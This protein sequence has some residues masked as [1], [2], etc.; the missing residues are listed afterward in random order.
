MEKD[1][2]F[3]RFRVRSGTWY[4]ALTDDGNIKEMIFSDELRQMLGYRGKEEFPDTL[5]TFKQ[6]IHPDDMS[7]MMD[8]VNST[9]LGQA[10]KF[11]VEYRIL[12]KNG[13]YVVVNDVGSLVRAANGRPFMM[14]GA[15]IDVTPI[16]DHDFGRK[17]PLKEIIQ[18]AY[19]EDAA[20][21]FG[22]VY[23]LNE[24]ARFRVDYDENG[25]LMA[26][27][28]N[29]AYWKMFGYTRA[30]EF[31]QSWP[32][33]FNSIVPDDQE[34]VLS[35]MEVLGKLTDPRDIHEE[36]FRVYNKDKSIH[37]IHVAARRVID[38]EGHPQQVVGIVTDISERKRDELHTRI[39]DI[40]SQ[41]YVTVNIVDVINHRLRMIRY[42]NR[43]DTADALEKVAEGYNYEQ[44]LMHYIDTYVAPEDR[45]RMHK[46]TTIEN[47]VQQVSEKEMYRIQFAQID[48]E[49]NR[50]HYQGSY[51]RIMDETGQPAIVVGFRDITD[52]VVAEQKKQ[53]ELQVAKE[54]AEAANNAKTAF[55]FNMSHDIRTPMNAIMG[56]RDLLEKY[57]EDPSRRQYYLVKMGEVSRVLLSIID[58]VLEMARIEKGT[59]ELHEN[60][61]NAY[62]F[63]DY[64]YS[65]FMP[66]MDKKNL[67]FI[68]KV[69]VKHQYIYCDAG[70]LRDVFLNVISNAY[71]YTPE[72][73]SISF[74]VEEVPHER[75]GWV[76]F[77][78][79]ISDTGIGMSQEF[80]PQ[81]FDAFARESNNVGN[82]IEGTGLGM[83]IVKR[84]VDFLE[85]TIEVQSKK[86]EGTSFVITIPHRIATKEEQ[87]ETL[88][89]VE[90]KTDVIQGKRV[91]LAEDNDIN[92][93]IA[94]EILTELGLM[95]EHAADGQICVDMLV[96]APA[97]YYDFI[98]M[99][100]QMPNMNGYEAT[101][102]IRK[103]LD[104]EKA[105]IPILAMTANAFEEDKRAA[106]NAGMNGHLAKPIDV[107]KLVQGIA[108]VLQDS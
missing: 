52:I 5:D 44:V 60:V 9:S 54:A 75:E 85:G 77:K 16:K 64:L 79:T 45:E 89:I 58:N 27:S 62:Q 100:I 41:D 20:K 55:L 105:H 51:L 47:L 32:S 34:L 40:F 94:I 87:Q 91:L 72:G 59:L 61:W 46:V 30:S 48:T 86:G 90:Y 49:G 68:R 97:H 17:N 6:Y 103:L 81:I 2:N 80:I 29:D 15:V 13:D 83:S 71:K 4:A 104:E 53:A 99:D 96:Q 74:E 84:L 57:Q 33:F 42:Y 56:Y 37:W 98:L 7:I 73:G 95:V 93:E 101:E 11:D 70:K 8:A 107:D 36:E 31:P 88:N 18:K 39:F 106:I 67:K 12:H 102:T 82:K 35:A 66:M 19:R 65:V 50:R 1:V 69:N 22:T 108:S 26:L 43:P 76:A 38:P 24:A 63:A 3:D 10:E 28:W 14:H 92:A 78:T 23:D 21:W 25:R